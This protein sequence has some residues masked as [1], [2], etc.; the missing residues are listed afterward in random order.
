MDDGAG[1]ASREPEADGCRGEPEP[2]ARAR[3]VQV[4]HEELIA[5][6]CRAFEQYV[7]DA[8]S[9]CPDTGLR[10][11]RIYGTHGNLAV[12]RNDFAA[13]ADEKERTVRRCQQQVVA[14]GRDGAAGGRVRGNLRRRDLQ[15]IQ[16]R[17]N[18]PGLSRWLRRLGD[19]RTLERDPKCREQPRRQP[20]ATEQ[21]RWGGGVVIPCL[22][23]G[24][25]HRNR[26][27]AAVGDVLKSQRR[28][29]GNAGPIARG[30]PPGCEHPDDL[31]ADNQPYALC[32]KDVLLVQESRRL[33]RQRARGMAWRRGSGP[34]DR[35]ASGR[36]A[37]LCRAR[38]P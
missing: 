6:F 15:R 12:D 36:G 34:P 21:P 8:E 25:C 9:V 2:N 27:L 32:A 30:P 11:K 20:S 17:L 24:R 33:A 37:D 1:P 7:G 4:R 18:G 23:S 35:A 13:S 14:Q 3:E 31:A 28:S 5:R 16:V 26:T 10:V 22:L 19:V 29:A 38:A